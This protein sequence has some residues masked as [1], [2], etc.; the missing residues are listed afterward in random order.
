VNKTD[1]HIILSGCFTTRPVRF[2]GNKYN[3][4]LGGK[5][6]VYIKCLN[7]YFWSQQNLG[8]T[9]IFGGALPLN[10]PHDYETDYN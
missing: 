9:K 3:T 6:F 10:A 8:D 5:I 1:S 4:F 2:G 7:K